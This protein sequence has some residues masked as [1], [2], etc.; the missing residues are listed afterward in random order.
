MATFS[1]AS[2]ATLL[3]FEFN[4]WLSVA[5]ILFILLW[6]KVDIILLLDYAICLH[7]HFD[8]LTLPK[9]GDG[10]QKMS[11]N[12]SIPAPE[13]HIH[14]HTSAQWMTYHWWGIDPHL[15]SVVS[16]DLTR[17]QTQSMPKDILR[18]LL[19]TKL[20][21]MMKFHPNKKISKS[22]CPSNLN[23][24][25]QYSREW[26]S[27]TSEVPYSY[28]VYVFLHFGEIRHVQRYC[29]RYAFLVGG[30]RYSSEW[31]T[32]WLVWRCAWSRGVVGNCATWP[33]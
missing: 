15:R 30:V 19:Q 8:Q 1:L 20:A 5:V 22:P 10:N 32:F 3:Q 29:C 13:W 21:L 18:V 2:S 27:N 7:K 4:N 6:L 16:T 31:L 17:T 25:R 11:I 14:R 33:D 23:S 28:L 26:V 24:T 9:V 12:W